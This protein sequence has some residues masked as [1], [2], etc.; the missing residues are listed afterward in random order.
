MTLFTGFSGGCYDC[1][2]KT[3][4]GITTASTWGLGVG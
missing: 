1:N 3:F 4:K 2:L